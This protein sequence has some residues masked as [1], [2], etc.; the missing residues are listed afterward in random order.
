[1]SL[2]IFQLPRPVATAKSGVFAIYDPQTDKTYQISVQEAIGATRAAMDWNAETTYADGDYVLFAGLTAWESLQNGN[3]GNVPAENSY[4]TAVTISPAD[5]ITDTPHANGLFTY[6][7]SKVIHGGI[8]YYLQVPAP[9]LSSDIDAE[10]LNGDWSTVAFGGMDIHADT[11]LLNAGGTAPGTAPL[12]LTTQAAPLSVVEQGAFELVG[13]SL[14]F[15]QLVKRRGV[16]MSQSVRTSTTTV[17]NSV[18]ESA[19]LITAEHGA[20]YL[21]VGK[22][23]EIILRGTIKQRSNPAASLTIRTKYAG[24]TIQTISTPISTAVAANT[25][26]EIR[27]T[28]TCRSVG[29]TGTMQINSVFWVDGVSNAHDAAALVTIDTTT[30]QNT[31]I[32]AQW[33]EANVDNIF[34]VHH[35]RVLCIEPNR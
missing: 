7:D 9:F 23:E 22:C 19:A 24:A 15:S 11:L 3:V 20:N 21:E 33:G 26:F 6:N 27:V 10:I 28:T 18:T 32:T 34:A 5:G 30:A 1:M 8:P 2:R 29:A 16:A 4:W 17:E 13:N 31:T 14:Q 35:G 25:P 12:K